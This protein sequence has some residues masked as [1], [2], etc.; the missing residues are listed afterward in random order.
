MRS[1]EE[2]ETPSRTIMYAVRSSR[3][4]GKGEGGGAQAMPGKGPEKKGAAAIGGKPA[5]SVRRVKGEK[6]HAPP[7]LKEKKVKEKGVSP[8]VGKRK[9]PPAVGK[10]K[11]FPERRE[12]RGKKGGILRPERKVGIAA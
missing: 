12:E 6:K 1:L 11:N 9:P 8:N 7:M 4:I 10:K 2:K 5:L 3:N